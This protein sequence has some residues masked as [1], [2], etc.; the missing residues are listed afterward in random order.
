M[1]PVLESLNVYTAHARDA[2]VAEI[3]LDLIFN[4]SSV[5]H[6][7]ALAE[8]RF[9]NFREPS[10]EPLSERDLAVL[11]QLHTCVV[12]LELMKLWHQ[13]SLRFREHR[14]VD[15]ISVGS[16]TDYDSTFPPSV[17]SFYNESVT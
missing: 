14:S 9:F 13:L 6:H 11:G 1:H 15:R 2:L 7:R 4:V 5:T 8:H 3:R 17:A 16:V 12:F 10:V